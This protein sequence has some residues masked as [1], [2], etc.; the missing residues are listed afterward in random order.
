VGV[1]RHVHHR[2]SICTKRHIATDADRLA[3][4]LFDEFHRFLRL[5]GIEVLHDNFRSFLGKEQAVARPMPAP[6]PMMSAT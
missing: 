2:L 3:A 5:S 6:T 1:H 4:G